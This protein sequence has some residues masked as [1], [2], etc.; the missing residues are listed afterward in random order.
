MFPGMYLRC[1]KNL[2][3]QSLQNMLCSLFLNLE[4]SF[5]SCR[6]VLISPLLCPA[7]TRDGEQLITI[8]FATAFFMCL[9]TTWCLSSRLNTLLQTSSTFHTALIIL[10][11]LWYLSWPVVPLSK[12][13]WRPLLLGM[14]FNVVFFFYKFETLKFWE[15]L[16][17]D[18]E[19]Y[20]PSN[21]RFELL[22]D[23]TINYVPSG[24]NYFSS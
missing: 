4:S 24:L 23:N 21:C 9:K 19:N 15:A 5:Q 11:D 16:F 13:F 2:Q 10:L 3:Y 17:I 22:C 12:D 7:C 8:V 1:F 20:S 6:W 14:Y 18:Q